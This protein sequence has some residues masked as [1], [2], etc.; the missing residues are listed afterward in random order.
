MI[1]A[2]RRDLR[3]DPKKLHVL[4]LDV[5]SR[6]DSLYIISLLP[7]IVEGFADNHFVSRSLDCSW[8][9]GR[10]KSHL[11]FATRRIGGVITLVATLYSSLVN[12]IRI[13]MRIFCIFRIFSNIS[14]DFLLN[15]F[16]PLQIKVDQYVCIKLNTF[17]KL[18]RDTFK[19]SNV[20]NLYWWQF[21]VTRYLLM[22]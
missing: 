3:S 22:L 9:A 6:G 17:L 21:L 2:H 7:A 20:Y 8:T 12:K 16:L 13:L 18:D 15:S 10:S 4:T 19:Y 1:E 5:D 14:I 11:S